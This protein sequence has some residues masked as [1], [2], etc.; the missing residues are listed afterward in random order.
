MQDSSLTSPLNPQY[1]GHRDA[2][3]RH[4]ETLDWLERRERE[5]GFIKDAP[6]VAPGS[7][8]SSED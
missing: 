1:T 2:K 4:E 5:L 7:D 3:R 6:S 8:K